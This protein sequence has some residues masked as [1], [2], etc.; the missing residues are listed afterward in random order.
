MRLVL[1]LEP[2][3]V[4]FT[5]ESSG[6][7]FPYLLTVGALRM[8]ARTG[9]Q[10]GIGSTENAVVPVTLNN[11]GRRAAAILRRPLRIAADIYDDA[12][13]L[14][15]SGLVQSIEYGRVVTMEIEA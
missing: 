7:A 12:G 10:F 3:A 8:A 5:E 11:A 14:F 13:A 4:E 6:G 9:S 15:F 1:A 2:S